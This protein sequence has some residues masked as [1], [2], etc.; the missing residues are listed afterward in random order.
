[1]GRVRCCFTPQKKG[2]GSSHTGLAVPPSPQPAQTQNFS[3]TTAEVEANLKVGLN[4]L[5][6]WDPPVPTLGSLRACRNETSDPHRGNGVFP[7]TSLGTQTPKNLRVRACAWQRGTAKQSSSPRSNLAPFSN[8][9]EINL[10]NLSLP[11]PP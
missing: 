11:D 9:F 7:P 1:M 3:A 8:C 2:T 4:L 6:T 5:A 10:W